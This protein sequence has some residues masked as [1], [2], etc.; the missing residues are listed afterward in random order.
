MKHPILIFLLQTVNIIVPSPSILV[1]KYFPNYKSKVK[2]CPATAMQ[3]TR[4]RVL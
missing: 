4:G 3:A 2:S 1:E